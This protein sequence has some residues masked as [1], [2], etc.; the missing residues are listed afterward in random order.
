LEGQRRERVRALTALVVTTAAEVLQGSTISPDQPLFDAGFDSVTAE[1]FV[2]RL[3]EKLVTGGWV[4]GAAAVAAAA[5]EEADEE[6]A[7]AAIVNSTTVFDC[8]TAQHMAEHIERSAAGDIVGS[9]ASAA[10]GA[11]ASTAAV[12]GDDNTSLAVVGIACRFP[13]GCDS[14]EAF[15]D[16]LKKGVDA[17]SGVPSERW[18]ADDEEGDKADDGSV[19]R[20]AFL[21][22]GAAW[23]FDS[24]FFDIPPAEARCMDPQQRIMLEVGYEALHRA[25]MNRESLRGSNTGVFVGACG[26][27]WA[28]RLAEGAGP[29]RGTYTSTGAAS[30]MLANRLSFAL[31]TVGPSLTIDTACSSSLVA[32][33]EACL[34]L[35]A[36][37][38]GG[39]PRAALVGGVNLLLSPGPFDLFSKTGM[40]APDGRCKVFA[41][42]AN[43]YGRG[44]GCGA[45]VLKRL[46]DAKADGNKILAVIKGTAVGH[47]GQSATLTAPNGLSQRAT[48][49]AALRDAGVPPNQVSYVEAHGTGTAL[50]DPV[51]FGA[52][53]AVYGK[54]RVAES[55]L[56]IGAVKSNI[57]HLEGA[58]G[59]SG[60]IKT[61]LVLAHG[62]APPNLHASTSVNPRIDLK[63]LPAVLPAPG[64]L[65]RL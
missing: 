8:P 43:G 15:W 33:R 24:T 57:G 49:S 29:P 14:P 64:K 34:H 21:K 45:V 30:S 48:I 41:A 42:G 13:G 54:N 2:G 52:L 28:T 9:S 38:A 63:A 12:E 53:E 59:I 26:T 60:L 35:R 37:A 22:D 40:L 65:T 50:G 62:A 1:E 18:S 51:E 39:R 4:K 11:G 46:E 44:E 3:Q 10:G 5:G 7:A 17:T 27:D 61:I 58:A 56:V 47:N 32:L 55:P 20:G 16:F 36:S 31:G 23:A 19:T 6:A 25:G